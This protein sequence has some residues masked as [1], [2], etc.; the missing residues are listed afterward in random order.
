M[1]GL[2]CNSCN[3]EFKDDSD[4]KLHYKS[5][6]HRYNLKRKVRFFSNN[7]LFILFLSFIFLRFNFAFLQYSLISIIYLYL[8]NPSFFLSIKTEYRN[9][10][11]CIVLLNLFVVSVIWRFVVCVQY[12]K[13]W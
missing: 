3:T 2:T 12:C 1:S 5:E 11:L 7:L 13:I 4:Q 10:K 9:W 6:W 8:L